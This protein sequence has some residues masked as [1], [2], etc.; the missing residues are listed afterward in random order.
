MFSPQQNRKRG[1]NRLCLKV[2]GVMRVGRKRGTGGR[3]GPNNV[4]TYE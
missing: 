4:Y 2:R 3:D 1:Q